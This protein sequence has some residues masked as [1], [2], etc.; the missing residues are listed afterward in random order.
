MIFCSPFLHL[1]LLTCLLFLLM[2]VLMLF[3]FCCYC[4]PKS[5]CWRPAIASVHSGDPL[6]L[7]VCRGHYRVPPPPPFL[8]AREGR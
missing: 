2:S 1:S 7:A 8:Y 3:P 5:L 4:V 6:T